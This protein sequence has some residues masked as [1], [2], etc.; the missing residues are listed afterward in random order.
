MAGGTHG[1]ICLWVSMYARTVH[2]GD[3]KGRR[4]GEKIEEGEGGGGL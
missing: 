1:R 4:S 3:I 2:A